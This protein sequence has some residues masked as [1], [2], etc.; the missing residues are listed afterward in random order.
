MQPVVRVRSD[1]D[2]VAAAAAAPSPVRPPLVRAQSLDSAESRKLKFIAAC[3]QGNYALVQ[4]AIQE[5]WAPVN[6]VDPGGYTALM[7]C[8]VSGQMLDMLLGCS[9]IDV[10]LTGATDGTTPLLLAA[11]Y[12]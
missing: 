4:R 1:S 6:A 9:G 12:R 5:G 3:R 2:A 11:R 7:R 10:N 8:C